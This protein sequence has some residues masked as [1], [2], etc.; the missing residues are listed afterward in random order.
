MSKKIMKI[1]PLIFLTIFLSNITAV[2]EDKGWEEFDA[3]LAKSA[4]ESKPVLIDFYTDWCHWCK[5]MDEKTFEND[6][7]KT[8]LDKYFVKIKVNAEERR[9]KQT[10]EG[11]TY[12]SVKLARTF[13]VTGYPAL[14]FLDKNQK[15]I[16]LVPGFLPPEKFINV[17]KY[18]KDECYT[19]DVS[20]EDFMKNGCKET[21]AK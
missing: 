13:G 7:V 19:K 2:A 12:N 1:I 8:Y 21:S 6:E 4:K 5:V 11:K 15:L 10:Y 9:D 14:A 17:L 18:M 16:T 3:G 20:F